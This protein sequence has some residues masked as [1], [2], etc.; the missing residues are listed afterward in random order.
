MTGTVRYIEIERAGKREGEK[1]RERESERERERERE[2]MTGR[3]ED[4]AICAHWT[5]N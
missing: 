2:S 4:V 3:D 1:V 5:F